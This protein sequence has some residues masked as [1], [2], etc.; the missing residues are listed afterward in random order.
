MRSSAHL[1]GGHIFGPFWQPCTYNQRGLHQGEYSDW[2]IDELLR[3]QVVYLKMDGE[4]LSR[5]I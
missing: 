1:P 2:T 5:E 4:A 3:E